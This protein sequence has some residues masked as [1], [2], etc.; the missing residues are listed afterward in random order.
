MLFFDYPRCKHTRYFAEKLTLRVTANPKTNKKIWK[1]RGKPRGILSIKEMF[2]ENEPDITA[3]KTAERLKGRLRPQAATDVNIM[4]VDLNVYD[5]L[6]CAGE[7]LLFE[8][9]GAL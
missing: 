4:A 8:S 3:Q 6:L 5:R 1:P 7:Q 9:E 2:A